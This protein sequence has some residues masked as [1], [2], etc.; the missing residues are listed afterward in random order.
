MTYPE[1]LFIFITGSIAGFLLEGIWRVIRTGMWE[2]HSATLYGPFC[3]IY[4]VGAAALYA[5]SG[6]LMDLSLWKQFLLYALTGALTEYAGSFLQEILLGSVSWDYSTRFLN[7]HGRICFS[8]TMVWGVL[9]LL[10]SRFCTPAA[11]RFFLA[12]ADWPVKWICI[13]ISILMAADLIISAG[14]LFRWYERIENIPARNQIE[15]HF[16]KR[17]DNEHMEK[18]YNNLVFIDQTHK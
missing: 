15:E 16:D 7:L 13:F 4:G 8:M 14:A 3:I 17:F 10:F 9:G 11:D 2:N 18:I 6:E 1:L 12:A 5:I